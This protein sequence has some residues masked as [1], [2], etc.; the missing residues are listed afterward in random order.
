MIVSNKELGIRLKKIR[1]TLGFSQ[2]KFAEVTNIHQTIVS[3]IENGKTNLSYNTIISLMSSVNYINLD[4][5]F[6]GR[7]DM[8]YGVT[9]RE[10]S[11]SSKPNSVNL[12]DDSVYL[13]GNKYPNN[14]T[15]DKKPQ[16]VPLIPID[17]MAGFGTGSFIVMDYDISDYYVVPDFK[18]ADF[19][20]RVKG[21]S[22]YPKY[23][24]GDIVACRKLSVDS[25]FFQWNKVYVL[26]TAQ[27]A[28]IKRII[29]AND[30]GYITCR[31]ENKDYPD[32]D[33]NILED[34]N[35]I[36]LIVGVIRLE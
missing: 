21:S 2:V 22:M 32:F 13:I 31:S 9:E 29:K 34:I 8:F 30:P 24:S 3:D 14:E 25:L 26:D 4:W 19:M 10:N 7:G 5:L 15:N 36:A 6:T 12:I 17:A 11:E 35:A 28:I 20:I 27:G 23:S 33:L 16:G 1:T 18:D